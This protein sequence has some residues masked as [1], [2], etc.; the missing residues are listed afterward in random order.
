MMCQMPLTPAIA[1]SILRV[2]WVSSSP[3]AAPD[4]VICTWTS[5]MSILG[6]LVIGSEWKLPIPRIIST[7]NV[8]TAGIGLRIDQA[9][10]LILMALIRCLA[11]VVGFDRAD[12][13]AVAQ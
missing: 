10:M 6:N 2:T 1:S 7:R 9:E 11:G 12:L 5:G 13:V 3:G 8:T 4:W